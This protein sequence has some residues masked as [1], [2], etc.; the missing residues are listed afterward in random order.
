MREPQRLSTL[1]Y[2]AECKVLCILSLNCDIL[3]SHITWIG[4]IL[5]R[6]NRDIRYHCYIRF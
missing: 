3:D 5:S 1:L 2:S 6:V 4:M